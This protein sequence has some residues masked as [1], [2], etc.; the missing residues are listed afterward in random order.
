M[1]FMI[2]NYFLCD[3]ALKHF[4]RPHLSKIQKQANTIIL[5]YSESYDTPDFDP[6]NHSTH[7]IIV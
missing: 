4:W 2:R 1:L 6:S 7:S 5:T 3:T